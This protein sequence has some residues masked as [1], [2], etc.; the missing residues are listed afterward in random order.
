MCWIPHL[1]KMWSMLKIL[2]PTP[3]PKNSWI[4]PYIHS[5]MGGCIWIKTISSIFGFED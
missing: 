2:L 1:G 4:R 3:P 5:C